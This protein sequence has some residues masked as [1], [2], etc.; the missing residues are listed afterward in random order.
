[1]IDTTLIMIDTTLILVGLCKLASSTVM[2]GFRCDEGVPAFD[3]GVF[4]LAA[5]RLDLGFAFLASRGSSVLTD[6]ELF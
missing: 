2:S 4:F 1:M 6:E 3:L 5:A